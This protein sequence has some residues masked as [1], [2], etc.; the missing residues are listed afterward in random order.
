MRYSSIDVLRTIAIFVMVVVHFLENLSG[1]REWSPDGFGAP[2]FTFLTGMSYRLW[3]SGQEAKQKE[4]SDISKVTIRRGLFLFGLGFVFNTFVWLPDDL[5]T[6]DVLTFI[7]ASMIV[8]NVVR[9]LRL[10]L[11][12]LTIVMALG[13]SPVL[14]R[15]ADYDAY[16]TSGY[17]DYE[18]TLSDVLLGFLVTGYFP[19]FPWIVFSITGFVVG[20]ILFAPK[21]S[22]ENNLRRTLGIGI[23]LGVFSIASIII[24]K[25]LPNAFLV[26]QVPTWSMYPASPVYTLGTLGMAVTLFVIVHRWIDLSDRF[27]RHRELLSI[28]GTFSRYSLTVYLLHHIV[29]IWP[30]WIYGMAVAGEPS[31]FWGKAIPYTVSL[32]LAFAFLVMCYFVLCFI[33]KRNV[34][35]I[36]SLMRW[37]CD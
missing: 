26:S 34:P 28:A 8:L 24:R 5:F 1:V 6:W 29:H 32:P 27:D 19:L 20:S 17:F 23:S 2:L 35:T 18:H 12:L 14:Q 13:I 33:Q 4:S 7:G 3:L 15:I 37:L 36:E 31:E 30:L 22:K 11:M 25:L 9:G 21:S 10:P 16:W